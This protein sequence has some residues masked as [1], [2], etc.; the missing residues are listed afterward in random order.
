MR[1][2]RRISARHRVSSV[3]TL[4]VTFFARCHRSAIWIACEAL[5]RAAV[6]YSDARSRLMISTLGWLW[7]HCETVSTE[8]SASRSIGT[9]R[10]Q[11]QMIVPYRSRRFHA[12]SSIPI[13]RGGGFGGNCCVRTNRKMVSGLPGNPS[14]SPNRAPASPPRANPIWQRASCNRVVNFA[15][16]RIKEGNCSAKMV[17][18]QTVLSQKKRRTRTMRWTKRPLMGRSRGVRV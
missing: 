12:Q 2:A 9:P 4:S 13:T 10:S 8:R 7:S 6:A 16:G 14:W 11:S 17:R 5:L 1:N 15:R 18:K 3:D